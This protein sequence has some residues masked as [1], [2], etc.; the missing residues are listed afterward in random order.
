MPEQQRKRALPLI[1]EQEVGR[2]IVP[3]II[4][5]TFLAYAY[6]REFHAKY[7][8]TRCIVVLTQDVKMLTTSR[9]AECHIVEDAAHPEGLY[10]AL[11]KI[12]REL[13]DEDPSLIPLLLGCDDRHALMFSAG[14]KRLEEAGYLV[15]CNDLAL[16]DNISQ[17]RGFYEL[18]DELSIPHPK[19]W[20][21]S[22]GSEGPETLPLDA[23]PYPCVA[24]PSDTTKF[25]NADVAHKRKAYEIETPAELAQVW[26]DVRASDYD[27]D[28][29]IQDFIPGGDEALR[30]L[31]TFS[32][33]EGNLVAV[34]GG[35]TAL[36][37]HSPT[38]LGNPLCI[39]GEREPAIIEYARKFLKR[40]K[41]Q[42]YGNFDIKYDARTGEYNFFEINVRAG[43][44]TYFTS[45]G[46]INFVSLVVDQYVLGKQLPY[47]EA[48]RPFVYNC[49]PSYV[50]K[51]SILDKELLQRVLTTLKKTRSPYPLFYTKDSLL[52][53]FWAMT[54]YYNQI[55]KFKR[56]FWDTD[57]HQY[58]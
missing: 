56:Y 41:Y 51:R 21:F 53:N 50:L 2:K 39:L 12:G 49:V 38:A 8:T 44:S 43:R 45:L 7:G 52:H 19:T 17:K 32:D 15:P 31:N 30:I 55:R 23:F 42:G 36:Q 18:C 46:G 3:V 27:G 22:A 9:F 47:R 16:L 28:F 14:K 10:R 58:K 20:Y 1:T 4:G 29:L 25:Q 40:T 57:G 11:E 13:H 37:D 5:G 24:K 6:I 33:A 34:S 26:Q 35:I 54:M 48:Y